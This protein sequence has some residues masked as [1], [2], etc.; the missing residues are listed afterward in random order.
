MCWAI[1]FQ[2]PG[3]VFLQLVTKHGHKLPSFLFYTKV[4]TISIYKIEIIK[5]SVGVSF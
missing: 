2:F 1:F 5:D 4:P 3:S